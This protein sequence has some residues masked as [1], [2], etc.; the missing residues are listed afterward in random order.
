[1]PFDL[2]PDPPG[3]D[4][5]GRGRRSIASD[6]GHGGDPAVDPSDLFVPHID[7]EHEEDLLGGGGHGHKTLAATAAL[8][9][10]GG[11]DEALAVFIASQ[12]RD[13]GVALQ[14]HAH[15]AHHVAIPI[16]VAREVHALMSKLAP[17]NPEQASAVAKLAGLRDR[18]GKRVGAAEDP[19]PSNLQR[20]IALY[21]HLRAGF[22]R[23]GPERIL[24]RG[25]TWPVPGGHDPSVRVAGLDLETYYRRRAEATPEGGADRSARRPHL[26]PQA[27]APIVRHDLS[28]LFEEL[29]TLRDRSAGRIVAL[30]NDWRMWLAWIDSGNPI[31]TL[32]RMN[33]AL[34]DP[35]RSKIKGSDTPEPIEAHRAERVFL[36]V[37]YELDGSVAELAR[38]VRTIARGGQ[39]H[40]DVPIRYRLRNPWDAQWGEG[41]HAWIQHRE[42]ARHLLRG[43]GLLLP[44]SGLPGA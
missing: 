14:G 37:G 44:E 28:G 24:D 12:A 43:A 11:H 8:A 40:K 35:D 32:L 18:L 6:H 25:L 22:D 9:P 41:G 21:R 4:Q 38:I 27:E 42:L 1:M 29:V 19:G 33:G 16:E 15:P 2:Y 30:H 26:H 7:P 36:L 10:T 34:L 13:F 39:S 17:D 31:L 5:G 20:S 23:I 3:R